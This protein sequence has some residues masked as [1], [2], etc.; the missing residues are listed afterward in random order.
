VALVSTFVV[1]VLASLITLGYKLTGKQLVFSKSGIGFAILVGIFATG[2]EYFGVLGFSKGVPLTT[3]SAVTAVVSVL[4]ITLYG[5]FLFLEGI[6]IRR[7]LAL[8]LAA[9]ASFLAAT[10]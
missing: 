7:I 1:G 4:M 3:A 6:T 9:I 2:I 5:K 10:G 8:I